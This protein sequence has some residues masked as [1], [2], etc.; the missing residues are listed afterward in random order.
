MTSMHGNHKDITMPVE[1]MKFHKQTSWHDTRITATTGY[2]LCFA[3]VSSHSILLPLHKLEMIQQ[4]CSY[5]Q[6]V[7]KFIYYSFVSIV[8]AIFHVAGN[9]KTS[10]QEFMHHS[11]GGLL[12]QCSR[13]QKIQKKVKNLGK[14]W[15][16]VIEH[17]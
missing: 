15:L 2:K 8:G 6:K 10:I 7:K 14:T 13:C 5:P 11:E 17:V 12:G 1:K 4:K 16:E 3:F 9:I